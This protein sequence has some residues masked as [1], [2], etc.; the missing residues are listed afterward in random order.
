MND[1][2]LGDFLFAHANENGLLD[3]RDRLKVDSLLLGSPDAVN[4]KLRY[5]LL[6]WLMPSDEE[7]ATLRRVSQQCV[8]PGGLQVLA[9]YHKP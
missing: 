6:E 7:L 5:E 1:W 2:T 8:D 4:M 9:Q 3:E